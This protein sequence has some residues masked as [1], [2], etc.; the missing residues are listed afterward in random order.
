MILSDVTETW[1]CQHQTQPAIPHFLI[2]EVHAGW[3]TQDS[4]HDNKVPWRLC[5]EIL[6][7]FIKNARRESYGPFPATFNSGQIMSNQYRLYIIHFFWNGACG[8]GESWDSLRFH[9]CISATGGCAGAAHRCQSWSFDPWASLSSKILWR[10]YS[11]VVC[12]PPCSIRTALWYC[13]WFDVVWWYECS[14]YNWTETLRGWGGSVIQVIRVS[15]ISMFLIALAIRLNSWTLICGDQMYVGS[16]PLVVFG[17]R[18]I[19]S[20]WKG[21]LFWDVPI[22]IRWKGC[23]FERWSLRKLGVKNWI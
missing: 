23:K 6:S 10:F 7:F 9:P 8:M 11:V 20:P 19:R 5:R 13:R 18:L 14:V 2:S 16:R 22:T 3:S 21:C 17:K 1:I 12:C 4:L 15:G